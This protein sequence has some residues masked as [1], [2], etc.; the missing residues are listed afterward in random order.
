MDK[1]ARA[2]PKNTPAL[3][4]ISMVDDKT[5]TSHPTDFALFHSPATGVAPLRSFQIR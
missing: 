3:H 5:I 2:T 4:F 1:D